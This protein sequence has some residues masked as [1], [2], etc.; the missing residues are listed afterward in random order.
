MKRLL[1]AA[2]VLALLSMAGLVFLRRPGSRPSAAAAPHP[3]ADVEN[4]GTAPKEGQ[5]GV[6]ALPMIRMSRPPK[7]MRR[8][9]VVPSPVPAGP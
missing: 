4:A 6:T 1:E 2:L 5:A 3:G 8:R 7:P 9:S